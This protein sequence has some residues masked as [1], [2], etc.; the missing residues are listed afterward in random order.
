MLAMC[1]AAGC[2]MV[3]AGETRAGGAN[4]ARLEG[5]KLYQSGHYAEALLCFDEVLARRGRDLEILNKRAGC[6]LALEQPEKALADCDRVNQ[7]SNWASRVFGV[8][9]IFD[10]NSTTL[11]IGSS[12]VFFAESW[13]NR[14]IALLMLERNEEALDSFKTAIRLW[15]RPQ[16]LNSKAGRAAAYQGLGQAYHR[17]REDETALKA[18]DLA[19]SINPADANGFAGRGDVFESQRM[20]DRAVP[21][22]TEAIRLNPEHSR[23]YCGRAVAYFALNSD[24]AALADLDKAIELDPNLGKAYSFRGAVHARQGRNALA[25][26]DYD[27][28]IRLLPTRAGSY[29][30]RGGLLVRMREFDRAHRRSRRS[31]PARPQTRVGLSEPR[32]GI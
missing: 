20:L 18:Y 10:P 5:L 3:C 27:T 4:D 11:P 28:L 21:D 12:D 2:V 29:K 16:D 7:H 8:N 14:G 22:Y 19:I 31:H 15:N 26:A 23:A 30:D 13:G 1:L 32:S 24:A 17:L 25:L 9:P 6:Y